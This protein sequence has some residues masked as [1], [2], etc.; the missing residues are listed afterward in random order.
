M[1]DLGDLEGQA[2]RI[3]Q[4]ARAQASQILSEAKAT[5]QTLIEQADS[6][7]YSQGFE[8]GMQDGSAAGSEEGRKQAIA[9]AR[10]ELNA[11]VERW[12]IALHEW[13]S[14]RTGMLEQARED[15]LRFAFQLS[16]RVIHRFVDRDPTI[17]QDQLAAALRLVSRS[18]SLQVRVNPQDAELTAQVLP[19]L[20]RSIAGC[21]HATQLA[22]DRIQPGGCIVVT[23]AGSVDSTIQTQ[24]DRIAEALIPAQAEDSTS[25]ASTVLDQEDSAS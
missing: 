13:E 9:A 11:L 10:A 2:N 12:N 7:G 21:E 23:A 15:V 8:R 16:R 20:A 6:R 1:L 4:Q 19:D 22:D 3:I 24:L 18:S 5:A 25:K 14:R 17:V